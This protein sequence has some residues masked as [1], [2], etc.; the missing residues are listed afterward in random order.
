MVFLLTEQ[1]RRELRVLAGRELHVVSTGRQSFAELAGIAGA[2]RPYVDAIHLRER[3][4]TARELLEGIGLLLA[5]GVP[6]DRIVINDRADVAAAAGVRGVQ[7]AYH[8]LE[9]SAVKRLFPQLRVGKSVHSAEEALQ[10]E[11]E[12]ADYVFYGHIYATASKPDLPARGIEALRR[13][14]DLVRIPV[15]AI[16][17]VKPDNVTEV[18]RA[19]A[20]G[21][22]VMS[23]LLEAPDPLSEAVAYRNYLHTGRES[24][25]QSN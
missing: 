25:E 24:H 17:G 7:L 18:L 15:I 16:G 11:A 4:K 22:A 5:A 10:A 14:T 6:A 12:G 1:E 13:L 21:I 19:G 20:A 3:T 8:S 23:G 9:V 2:I